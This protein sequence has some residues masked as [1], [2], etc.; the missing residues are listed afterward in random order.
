MKHSY[1]EA[2]K[3]KLIKAP[4]HKRAFSLIADIGL[5]CVIASVIYGIHFL[6]YRNT[7]MLWELTDW[8]FIMSL[9][10]HVIYLTYNYHSTGQ[11]LGSRLFNI[12]V[13]SP[14]GDKL[15]LWKSFVRATYVTNM[16]FIVGLC[17]IREVHNQKTKELYSKL[18]T[19]VWD[20]IAQSITVTNGK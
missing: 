17:C 14:N 5:T 19:T 6:F 2:T 16:P 11:T 15:T 20:E 12:L 7:D 10:Y 4:K 9:V 1:Y 8:L 13:L 3:M 18:Q